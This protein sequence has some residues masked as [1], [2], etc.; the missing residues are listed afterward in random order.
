MSQMLNLKSR[1]LG[2]SSFHL[3]YAVT[4]VFISNISVKK[5][6]IVAR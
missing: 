6:S 4:K 5:N 2:I 3:K 1:T